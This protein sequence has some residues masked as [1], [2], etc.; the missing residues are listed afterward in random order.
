MPASTILAPGQSMPSEAKPRCAD[1]QRV[2]V[3]EGGKFCRNG[4][5]CRDSRA[6]SVTKNSGFIGFFAMARRL[7]ILMP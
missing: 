3:N 7:L 2:A 5:Y 6:G 4:I 1:N